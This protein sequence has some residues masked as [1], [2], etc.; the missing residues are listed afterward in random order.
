MIPKKPARTRSGVDTAQNK[1][2]RDDDRHPALENLVVQ[3]RQPVCWI[4]ESSQVPPG[5]RRNVHSSVASCGASLPSTMRPEARSIVLSI[6]EKRMAT[7]AY[8]ASASRHAS[9]RSPCTSLTLEI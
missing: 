9:A 6:N 1:L 8:S 5:V 2:E 3:G 7:V 4:A